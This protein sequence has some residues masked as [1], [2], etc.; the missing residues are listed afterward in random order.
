MRLRCAYGSYLRSLAAFALQALAHGPGAT[1]AEVPFAAP[2][3]PTPQS[4]VTQMLEMAEVGPDDYV[5]DL[6]SGDGRIVLT[7][8]RDFGARG[9]GVEILEDLVESARLAAEEQGIADRVRFVQQDLFATDVSEA[10]LV[11]MYLLPVT[12]SRLRDK[13]LRELAPGTRVVSHDYRVQGWRPERSLTLEHPEKVAVTGVARTQ[14]FLYRVPALVEGRWRASAPAGLIDPELEFVFTQ[15]IAD[16]GG[17]AH[18]D[19]SVVSVGDGVVSGRVVTFTLHHFRNYRFSGHV[20]D[21]RIE[22][23]LTV[24]D[25]S[26]PWRAVRDDTAGRR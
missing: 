18:V 19:D 17:V 7:A 8:A 14:L 3:V 20:D 10:T 25:D 15:Q 1:A 21:G 6:G 11:T 13:L 26:G 4:I 23:T 24:G 5:I 22:G 12:V 9:M 2:Y 16:I